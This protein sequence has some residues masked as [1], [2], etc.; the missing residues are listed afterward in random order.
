[1]AGSLTNVS[2]GA[3]L[4]GV[5]RGRPNANTQPRP[6]RAYTKGDDRHAPRPHVL[7]EELFD[8]VLV[9]ERR[10]ADRF[11]ET[12]V[13]ILLAIQGPRGRESWKPLVEALAQ[14]AQDTDVIGWFR[15]DTVLGLVRPITDGDPT[16]EAS[17]VAVKIR[18]FLGRR[19]T[20]DGLQACSMHWE[21]Y[22]PSVA[23]LPP[24]VVEA[25]QRRT[26][27]QRLRDATKRALD[28]VGSTVLLLTLLP[29]I[30][31]V[32][33]LVKLT[34]KGP[35]FF[36]QERVGAGGRTFTMLKFR[37]M[38]ADADQ[39]IHQQYVEDFIRSS[40]AARTGE[41]IFK[42]VNDP[43]VTP[44]GHFL[45]R[46]SLDELPQFLNVLKGEMSLVGPRPP[47]PYEVAQYKSWHKRRVLEA[48]P[49]ITGPW[50]VNGRSRT[51]FEEMV[52]LDLRYARRHSVWT[53][54]KII[55]RT[56]KAM[57]SG[58]GAH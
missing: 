33:A 17:S 21:V 9:R 18:R 55:I 22:S 27:Q 24:A 6:L 28:V 1:V 20:Q 35:V 16:E 51:T 52:R 48:K 50:Q 26:P 54:L 19:G 11:D 58:K 30:A 5:T 57:I 41:Q 44:V 47:L 10:R 46:S 45:R 12:F 31:L 3:F 34:S 40:S 4:K 2:V 29:L 38:R 36:P 13:L 43:R 25:E 39:R 15:Q 7:S 56:P 49:G 14:T 53:D 8:D 42:I 32:S 23:A 37:T